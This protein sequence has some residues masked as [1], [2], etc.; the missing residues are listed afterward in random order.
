MSDIRENFNT[1]LK[2]IF[3][4]ISFESNLEIEKN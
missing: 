4:N 1:F 2:S 3:E